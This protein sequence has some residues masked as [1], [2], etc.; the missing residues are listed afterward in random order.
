M[1]VWQSDTFYLVG[2]AQISRDTLVGTMKA[3]PEGSVSAISIPLSVTD[4][5]RTRR[6]DVGKTFL[7]TIGAGVAAI[8]VLWFLISGADPAAT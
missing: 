6:L 5:V 8:T 2:N 1:Q 4:S 3:E 7:A